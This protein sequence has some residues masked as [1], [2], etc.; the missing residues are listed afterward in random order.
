MVAGHLFKVLKFYNP[1][2]KAVQVSKFEKGPEKEEET[3]IAD[4][5]MI[6]TYAT[7][8]V[9]ALNAASIELLVKIAFPLGDFGKL[10]VDRSF[11]PVVS[12]KSLTFDYVR[13]LTG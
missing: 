9:K 12:G 6:F 13:R 5:E 7:A 1:S 11:V 4:Y 2:L 10:N 8:A 3:V